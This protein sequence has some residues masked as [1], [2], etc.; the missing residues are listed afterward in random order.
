MGQQSRN[1]WYESLRDQLLTHGF[2]FGYLKTSDEIK[3][4]FL[5]CCALMI[6]N[7]AHQITNILEKSNTMHFKIAIS[8]DKNREEVYVR[9]D[10]NQP[11]PSTIKIPA[12][13]IQENS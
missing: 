11:I 4:L 13:A 1:T 10:F 3:G 9:I 7:R 2:N 5:N 12:R 8:F 6:E